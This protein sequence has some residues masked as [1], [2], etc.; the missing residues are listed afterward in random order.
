M[1]SAGWLI[2]FVYLLKRLT[3]R[4]P[5][6]HAPLFVIAVFGLVAIFLERVLVVVPLG[7]D[8]EPGADRA[9]RPGHHGRVPRALR[10]EPPLVHGPLRP[11]STSR[12]PG[13]DYMGARDMAPQAPSLRPGE[14]V[15]LLVPAVS[16]PGLWPPNPQMFV[17]PGE[18]VA[19][20]S[21]A[22]SEFDS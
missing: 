5:Q 17:G 10:P 15:A 3:G 22:V 20:P 21:R 9:A 8:A 14:A 4:P 18:A 12:T 2:P 13:I 16:G 7:V 1:L 11:S 6:R 19:L